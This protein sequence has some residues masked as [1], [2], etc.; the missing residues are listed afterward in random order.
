MIHDIRASVTPL[1]E[2]KSDF[3]Y[4]RFHGP[5]SNY[6]GS[7]TEDFL[8]E[9]SDKIN[10]W[11]NKGKIVFVYF[12]NTLGEAYNNL[13]SLNELMLLKTNHKVE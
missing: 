6:R 9:Y 1:F 13:I 12:N 5:E 3:V 7:Y 8:S 11:T 4:L 2:S 10:E